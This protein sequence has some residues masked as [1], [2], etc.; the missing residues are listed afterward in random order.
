MS[1]AVGQEKTLTIPTGPV[2]FCLAVGAAA[3][4][5]GA[6]LVEAHL[7]TGPC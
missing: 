1:Q 5:T 3:A 6:G 4:V 7:T 2:L